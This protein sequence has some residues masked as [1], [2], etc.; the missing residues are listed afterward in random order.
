MFEKLKNL[1]HKEE[2]L[3]KKEVIIC[4]HGFGRR[5]SHEYDNFLLWAKDEY[6]LVVF[7]IYDLKDPNDNNPNIWIKRCEEKCESYLLNGYEISLI[8]FS[9]GGVI[10]AHLAS[11]YHPRKLFLISPAF[12]YLHVGNIV[13]SAVS[14]FRKNA[15][16]ETSSKPVI[17]SNFY[18]TFMDVVG[19]CKDDISNVTC[20]VCIVHGD[21]DETIPLRSSLHAYDKITHQNK[22]LFIIHE[23]RHRLMMHTNTGYETYQIF[24]LFMN[25]ILLGKEITFAK[26]IFEVQNE[27]NQ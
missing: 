16:E 1:F 25:D 7:D 8:G 21:K 11:K 17:P 22:R 9:M 4:I 15:V 26:D 2:I 10:A 23:G 12:D 13:N 5:L 27:N 20:P 19:I 18:S 24:K 6:E 3:S 14:M